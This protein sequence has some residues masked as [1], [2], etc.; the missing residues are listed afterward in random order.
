MNNIKIFLFISIFLFL[1]CGGLILAQEIPLVARN[2][3]VVDPEVKIGDIVSQT[4]EGLIRSETPYDE[5]I[6]GVISETPIMVF[7]KEGPDT[8]PVISFGETLTKISNMA[9]EIK[10]GDFITSSDRP[11]VGQKAEESGF[12]VGVAM[13]NFNQ[14]EG[15]I[16]V[17]VRPEKMLFSTEVGFGGILDRVLSGL[18]IPE[19][20]PEVFR[21]LFALLVAAIS[22][23]IG[24]ISFIKALREGLAAVGRNPLAK[25]S[26]RTAM[27]LNLIGVSI[28]TLAGLALA[29]FVILY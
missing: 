28:L 29:L 7:G 19:T 11:G 16:L 18:T 8:M 1:A 14:E 12:I 9:G 5:N 3:E 4:K 20:I 17:F 24:F 6:I 2:L 10:K 23:I 22:F 21:Y 13:E 27:I 25:G 26:I 15:L